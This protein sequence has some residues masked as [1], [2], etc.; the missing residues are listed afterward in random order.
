HH[1]PAQLCDLCLANLSAAAALY[2][3]DFLAG[4]TLAD[5]PVFDD[6]QMFQTETLRQALVGALERLGQGY[7][8]RRQWE[9]ALDYAK[10][11]ASIEPLHEAAH[12]LLMT[13]YAL[14]DQRAAALAQYEQ[15]HRLLAAEL[16]VEPDPK[17][18]TLYRHI[19]TGK[20]ALEQEL[21]LTPSQ[22]K[23]FQVRQSPSH[24]LPHPTTSFV[25]REAEL[26]TLLD[27][28]SQPDCRLLNIVGPGG[29]GKTRLALHAARLLTQQS[30]PTFTD[31][32]FMASL[33]AVPAGEQIPLVLAEAVGFPFSGPKASLDQLLSYLQAKKLLLLL[34]NFEH[35]AE[36]AALL[37]EMLQGLSEVK[38]LVT[39]RMRLNLYE[40]WLLDLSG[41]ETPPPELPLVQALDYNA[42]RLF[43]QRARQ[44][45]PNFAL[46]ETNIGPVGE[47]CRAL[48]GLPLAIELAA[49]L[50]R[51]H[52]CADIAQQIQQNLD[53]LSSSVRNLPDRQ[54]SLRAVFDH[55]WQLLKPAEQAAFSR[56]S[57]FR[58]GFTVEA[59]TAVTGVSNRALSKLVD[60]SLLQRGQGNRYDIH[61]RLRQFGSEKLAGDRVYPAAHARYFADLLFQQEEAFING[62]AAANDLVAKEIDNIRAAWHWAVRHSDDVVLDRLLGS[63]TAWCQEKGWFREGQSWLVQATE[64]I[65]P[66]ARPSL[67]QGR[68]TEYL[69]RFYDHLGQYTEAQRYA[70]ASLDQF[71]HLAAPAHIASAQAV[72]G[73]ALSALGDNLTAKTMLQE[74]LHQFEQLGHSRGQA[75]VLYYLSFVATGLGDLA[76]GRRCV[77]TSLSLYRQLGDWRNTARGLFL[78]GNYE[79]GAGHFAQALA[80]YEESKSLHQ[81][82]GHRV[83]VA[84]CLKNEGLAA[85]FLGE[86]DQAEQALQ[87]ALKLYTEFG[88][89]NGVAGSSENL[90]RV[91]ADQGNYLLAKTYLEQSLYDFQKIGATLRVGLGHGYLGYVLT[92]LGEFEAAG[93]HFRQAL[94]LGLAT[95]AVTNTLICLERMHLFWSARQ[96]TGLAV[97]TL[98]HVAAHISETYYRNRARQHLAALSRTV[99]AE[100][101]AALAAKGEATPLETLVAATLAAL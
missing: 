6:W 25:G 19:R 52:S 71:R 60:Q 57:V 70:E 98:A 37:V 4:F 56:L 36:D 72:L 82:L 13:L 17:T 47:I 20:L 55:S 63:F 3:A 88:D 24:N 78:L 100:T 15:C 95:K 9:L 27:Q 21:G 48:E 7:G 31:G 33:A 101:F 85:F 97:E 83:G 43:A 41:L 54:R 10:R 64:A 84:D 50:V 81:R 28:L 74:S 75:E 87:A 65:G 40:E 5:G 49:A 79:I 18:Q 1:P 92:E 2:Q 86:L 11:W 89:P 46:T 22:I 93:P 8:R 99:P 42:V 45:S 35:L 67:L 34:D 38:L 62:D 44:M 29:M 90:G 76:E 91:I 68:L 14:S 30:N 53:F 94:E 66:A 39:S 80:Y 32:V 51:T 23:P 69:A 58:G 12:R 77:E 61:E 96:M 73:F 26:K 59:A 16:H